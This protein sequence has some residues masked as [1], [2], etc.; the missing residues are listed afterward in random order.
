MVRLACPIEA[1]YGAPQLGSP[2]NAWTD[3]RRR[4]FVRVEAGME[5]AETTWTGAGHAVPVDRS[6]EDFFELEQDRLIAVQPAA[7]ISSASLY[8]V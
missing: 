7:S 3:R 8:C 5:Q 2:K 6:F 4:V 1:P